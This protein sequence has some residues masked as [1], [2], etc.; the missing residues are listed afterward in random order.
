MELLPGIPV[1]HN[2]SSSAKF[3]R[4][5]MDATCAGE[6]ELRICFLLGKLSVNTRKV[7]LSGGI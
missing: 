3:T 1:R 2:A 7:M 4:E 5:I 6:A